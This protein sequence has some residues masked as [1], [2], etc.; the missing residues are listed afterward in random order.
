MSIFKSNN[1]SFAGKITVR[2]ISDGDD[3]EINRADFA[4]GANGLS[5]TNSDL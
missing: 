2:R 3:M 4:E 5:E 1:C